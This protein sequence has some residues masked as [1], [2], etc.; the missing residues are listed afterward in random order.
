[1]NTLEA[2][3]NEY[4]GVFAVDKLN[5]GWDVLNLFDIVRLYETRDFNAST[6]SPG[7]TTMSE[8]QLI[9]R[10]ARYCPFQISVDQELYKRKFDQDVENELK[11]CEELYYHSA[12][13]PRYIFELN[14]ALKEIGIIPHE[15]KERKLKLKNSFK[16]SAFYNE[17]LIYLNEKE[18]Y[19]R[20]DIFSLDASIIPQEFKFHLRTGLT[21]TTD[22]FEEP[23]TR[24]ANNSVTIKTFDLIDFGTPIIRKAIDKL[25]FYW[26]DNLQSFF[27]NLDSISEFIT[28]KKYLGKIKNII[29]EGTKQQL[30]NLSSVQKLEFVIEV[31]S[32]IEETI[33]ADKI[34]YKGSKK[35]NHYFL[36]DKIAQEKELTF[37]DG[38]PDQEFGKS[39]INTAESRLYLDLSEKDWFVYEDNFGT[40]EKKHF[41]H[42]VNKTHD[43]LKKKY[44][45]IYLV[46]N[47]RF[48][49]LFNF[50]DGRAVE[51]DF[52]LYLVNDKLKKS[53]YYQIFV[54]P[55]G[56]QFK[57][58]HGTFEN[59]KESWK[60]SFLQQ[61]NAEGKLTQ[62]FSDKEYTIWG[63]PFYNKVLEGDFKE[64][65]KTFVF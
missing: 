57:D 18:K 40:S 41:I 50:D 8:A 20:S 19:D 54:E 64:S 65:F 60:Q 62:I 42:F 9:G 45:Q 2:E 16:E 25:D 37:S 55:K 10:G 51:P 46:R 63:M 14:L 31:L 30:D 3:N 38:G 6:N 39:M 4:R 29:I 35:F 1:V 52:V 27:P 7:K 32:K 12:H 59:S 11:I 49:K 48:F 34:E 13:N 56:N 61:L 47:E 33:K 17:A 28:S 36:K 22:I 44:S 24:R 53:V 15:K 23:T 58:K 5:D 21:Q 26:F 43:K